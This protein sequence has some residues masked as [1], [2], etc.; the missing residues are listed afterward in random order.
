M[1]FRGRWMPKISNSNLRFRTKA[2]LCADIAFVLNSSLHY[3]TKFAVLSEATWVWTEFD[4]KDNGCK[5]WSEA[6]WKVQDDR[7]QLVHEHVIPKSIVIQRLLALSPA[8]A[9]SVNQ[10]MGSYCLGAVITRKEDAH[11][12]SHGLRSTMPLDWDEQNA[13]ARYEH[14]GIVLR[15]PTG[16][17]N[18]TETSG[19]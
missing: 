1:H 12:N 13:W 19:I 8:T 4:G 18:A 9:E 10:L 17:A 16:L 11:L 2:E 6:A 14:A 5:Y 7:R 3:G 15:Q